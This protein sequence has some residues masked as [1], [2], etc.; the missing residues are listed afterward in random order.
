[1][2]VEARLAA[3]R[4]AYRAALPAKLAELGRALADP[5]AADEARALAHR[6]RGTAATYGLADVSAACATIE[7]R[8]EAGDHGGAVAAFAAFTPD[9]AG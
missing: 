7:A 2:S 6:L 9:A 8:L 3:L 4:A 1:M 5:A